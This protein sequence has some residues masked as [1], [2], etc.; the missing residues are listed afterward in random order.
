MWRCRMHN[1]R[2]VIA[3]NWKM[4]FT[5]PQAA[6]F[7]AEIKGKIDTAEAD[8]VLCV[9]YVSLQPVMDEIKGTNVK[10]GA[11]NM[12]YMASGAYTGEVSGPMLNA[13]GVNYAIIGHSERREKFGETDTTVNLR[14]LSAIKHGITPIICVGESLKQRKEERTIEILV[15]QIN[16]A[17]DELT[18]EQ[19]AG[20][21]I[22]YEPIWAIGTGVVATVEQAE[23][24]CKAIRERIAAKF[25]TQTA[26][27]T[28]IL[29]GG[30]VDPTNAK[31]LFAQKNIDGGL[32]GGASM[33]P[34]FEDVV[35]AGLLA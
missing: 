17:L 28:R 21:I 9:P 8:V 24:S 4:N 12:H 30:S 19:V 29:Y 1:R 14:T 25:G 35:K 3:G 22:A 6:K 18:A 34:S 10:A 32:V 31:E 16:I 15:K 5:P 27:A 11:Q 7:A 2:K 23:E 20:V 33:K 26:N 13:M